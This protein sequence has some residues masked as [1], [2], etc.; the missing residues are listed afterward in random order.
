LYDEEDRLTYELQSQGPDEFPES[1]YRYLA[2]EILGD[3]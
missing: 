2:K 1:Y 3:Q